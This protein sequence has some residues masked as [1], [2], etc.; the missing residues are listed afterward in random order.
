MQ[1]GTVVVNDEIV[2]FVIYIRETK[3]ETTSKKESNFFIIAFL[4]MLA[5]FLI[6]VLMDKTFI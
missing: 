5:Y 6:L 1:N 3:M 2:H 4:V